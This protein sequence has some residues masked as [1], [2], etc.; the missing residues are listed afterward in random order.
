VKPLNARFAAQ[1][2]R[3]RHAAG[4]S[5][6]ELAFRANLHRTEIGLLERGLRSPAL[7][8]IVK[9][10]SGLEVSPKNLLEGMAWHPGKNGQ[11]GH[12]EITPFPEHEIPPPRVKRKKDT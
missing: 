9:L 4:I 3:E 12:F 2:R 11:K 1:L 10:A 5:Q 6:E 7:G 8:T